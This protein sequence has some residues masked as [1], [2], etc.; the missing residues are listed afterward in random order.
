M[1]QYRVR[2]KVWR[3]PGKGGWHFAN[4]SRRQSAEI[5]IRFAEQRRGWGSVPVTV[6]I[7]RTVWQTSLFPDKKSPTYIFAIKAD[8]RERERIGDGDT[9]SAVV[10]VGKAGPSLARR[11]R[12]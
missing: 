11:A 6:R 3:Y 1:P 10:T 9:I 7:G 12:S 5:R 8:V 2:A 4:L